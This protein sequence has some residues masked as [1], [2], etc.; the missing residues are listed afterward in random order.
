[1]VDYTIQ[2]DRGEVA[3]TLSGKIYPMRPSYE[4]QVAVEERTGCSLEELWLRALRFSQIMFAAV[5]DSSI[6]AVPLSGGV[7]L[8]LSETA[9]IV[10]EFVRAAGLERNDAQLRAWSVEKTGAMLAQ[11]ARGA[12]YG[13][14]VQILNSALN[15]GRRDPKDP[16][17]PAASESTPAAN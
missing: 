4:A 2:P 16:P 11:E 17:P 12:Y 9:A 13:A 7:G 3:I 1:M 6:P 5:Q 10:T 8:K 15:G 14:V